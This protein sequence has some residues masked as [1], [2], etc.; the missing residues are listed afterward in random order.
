MGK[1]VREMAEKARAASSVLAMTNASVKDAALRRMADT[2]VSSQDVVLAANSQDV[3]AA[4]DR[5][6]NPPMI[7]RL[8][9]SQARIS[10]M[11]DG[12]RQV[13]ALPDPIGEVLDGWRRPNGLEISRVRVP[14]G[15]VG[16]IYEAR[17]NVTAEAASL[18]LKSGNACVLRGGSEALRSNMAIA[19]CLRAGLRYT[20]LP[21][22]AIQ[23][24]EITDRSAAHEMMRMNGLIDVLIPRG[25]AGLIRSVVE[26]ATVPV[27]ETGTGNCHTY[28]DAAANLKMAL[29]IAVNAKCSRPSVCNAMETLLVHEQVAKAFLPELAKRMRERGVELRGCERCCQ[30]VPDMVPAT[31]EDWATEYLALTLAVRVVPDIGAAIEHIERYGTRHSEAIITEDVSAAHLFLTQVDAACV[32][33]NASTRFT[34]GGE[35]GFGAEVG[36]S[37]QKLHARGPMGLRE[38]TS[39]KYVIRGSGQIRG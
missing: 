3:K 35:F 27:I 4:R 15:V 36:I 18:C 13:S 39:T 20:D 26:E 31:E 1:S 19:S 24:V 12:L 38:L 5:G 29:D 8:T 37:N 16:L 10:A 2:L 23:L 6:V 28:V 33:L 30:I 11:A 14:L 7:E 25:G 32:Y 21:E 22:D 17:P 9:L 34:D